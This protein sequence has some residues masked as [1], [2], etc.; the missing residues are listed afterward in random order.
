[1]VNSC[2]RSCASEAT[3]YVNR[4]LDPIEESVVP[5]RRR[6]AGF[7]SHSMKDLNEAQRASNCFL[8]SP[9]EALVYAR[10]EAGTALC[11]L[12]PIVKDYSVVGSPLHV[13]SAADALTSGVDVFLSFTE[14]IRTFLI[15]RHGSCLLTEHGRVPV[16]AEF[17]GA[18]EPHC[19]H[20]HFLFFPRSPDVMDEVVEECQLFS[21]A[22]SLTDALVLA[23]DLPDY[24]L[25]SPD[26]HEYRVFRSL[27]RLP[28]QFARY[29]V[30]SKLGFP[31][32]A[33]WRL[34]ANYS[35]AKRAAAVLRESF[36]ES[37]R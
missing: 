3:W 27:G 15:A 9:D 21:A 18:H 28:R 2:V 14:E 26:P 25:I 36:W 33:D 5:R 19:F 20:A 1:M 34:H 12:G 23:G 7:G 22:N 4:R 13:R 24:F 31:E 11:G 35:N 37:H 32:L 29:M 8:C 16:C 10:T 17:S 30:A 6:S